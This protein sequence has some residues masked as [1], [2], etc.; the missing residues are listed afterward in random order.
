[1]T[2]SE[3]DLH[4]FPDW[5]EPMGWNSINHRDKWQVSGQPR[6]RLVDEVE[7]FV[8]LKDGSFR[9]RRKFDEMDGEQVPIVI[10]RNFTGD[11]LWAPCLGAHHERQHQRREA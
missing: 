3:G 11:A 6:V 9:G 8:V 7:R 5:V 10:R 1:M 2:L 4:L